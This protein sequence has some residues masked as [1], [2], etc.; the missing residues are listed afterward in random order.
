M[1][2][3]IGTYFGYFGL[4]MGLMSLVTTSSEGTPLQPYESGWV[5]FGWMLGAYLAGWALGPLVARLAGAN[6]Q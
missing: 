2:H 1:R 4:F 3:R 5:V 6:Q